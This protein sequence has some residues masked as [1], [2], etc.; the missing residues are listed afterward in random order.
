MNCKEVKRYLRSGNSPK[1]A[2]P[3]ALFAAHAR[4]CETC[5]RE[6]AINNLINAL[7]G[8]YEDSLPEESPWDE[9]RLA[10]RIKSRIQEMNE[11]GTGT[12]EAAVISVKGWLVAFGAAAIL[13]LVLSSQ[14]ATNNLS[15]QNDRDQISQSSTQWSE[16]IISNNSSSI[17][18]LGEDPEHAQ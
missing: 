13:L 5:G 9:V 7:V 16:E 3:D 2:R 11:R 14:L 4:A 10:N 8:S 18:L 15:D 1:E 12:W 17:W 6:L